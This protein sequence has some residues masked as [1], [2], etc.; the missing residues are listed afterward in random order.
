M[1]AILLNY[2]FSGAN[3]WSRQ[4]DTPDSDNQYVNLRPGINVG[5]W[6]LRN[7]DLVAQQRGE[8][9]NSWDTVYT[10]AQRNIKSLQG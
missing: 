10:Y 6:R 3:N 1:P 2:S 4:N 5:P 9:S 8:S 7:Y